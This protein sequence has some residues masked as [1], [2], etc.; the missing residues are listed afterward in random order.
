[1]QLMSKIGFNTA[2][3]QLTSCGGGRGGMGKW[4]L[5]T[6]TSMV[7]SSSSDTSR[8]RLC[9][10]NEFYKVWGQ[11]FSWCLA[12][13]YCWCD[14]GCAGERTTDYPSMFMQFRLLR[15][16]FRGGWFFQIYQKRGNEKWIISGWAGNKRCNCKGDALAIV[17]IAGKQIGGVTPDATR[18][19]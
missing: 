9:F 13:Y 14:H 10:L 17:V 8:S 2:R 16:Y 3:R 5:A 15:K 1:M 12:G 19:M 4:I 11:S 6:S 7:A 18:E